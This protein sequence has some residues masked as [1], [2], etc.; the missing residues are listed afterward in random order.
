MPVMLIL[1]CGY[2]GTWLARSLRRDG[3][4]IYAT[5]R[6][7]ERTKTLTQ[8][9]IHPLLIHTPADIPHD[10][11][12]STDAVL[13][14]IPLQRDGNRILETQ[15]V[16]L[17][18]LAPCMKRLSWAG[19]LSTT[20]VYGDAAGAW[21]DENHSCRP[22]SERG[23]QRLLAEQAWLHSSLPAEVF[24]LAGIYGPGRNIIA[25]LQ[26]GCY[27]VVRWSP[28]HFSNRIHIEDIIRAIRAAMHAPQPARIMNIADDLPLPHD[29]YAC[30]LATYI[31]APAP[32]ILSPE[33]ARNIL[34]PALLEFFRDNKRIS[35]RKLH[36]HLL[37][38]LR[39]P[40]FRHAWRTLIDD[41]SA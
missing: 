20:G 1:G 24:R 6:S 10:I 5:T 2:C 40:S 13:D 3:W 26:S 4:R 7:A 11:L 36:E 15:S 9:G 41:G 33:E 28:P 34:S 27:R 39:Y 35:N 8:L 12:Q 32:I 31:G 23:Q 16:W 37:P 38:Q 25:R 14:S 29:Q 22:T 18:K 30:E 19:Y 21:V 17:P